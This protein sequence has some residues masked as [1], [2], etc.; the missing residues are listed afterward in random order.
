MIHRK[1]PEI[2]LNFG[3]NSPQSK[4]MTVFNG[5]IAKIQPPPPHS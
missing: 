2:I 5:N 1:T 4:S 3:T